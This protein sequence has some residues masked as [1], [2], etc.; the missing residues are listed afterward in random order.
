MG[1][2]NGSD[3]GVFPYSFAYASLTFQPTALYN[4]LVL[5]LLHNQIFKLQLFSK[6]KYN[7]YFLEY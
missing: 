4:S 1:E 5:T 3:F 2:K 6:T 7:N